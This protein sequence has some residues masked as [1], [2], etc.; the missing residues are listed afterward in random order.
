MTWGA[1]GATLL[2]FATSACTPLV[3]GAVLLGLVGVGALTSKCY[4]YLD[5]TVLDAD[6]RKTCAATVTASRRGKDG[7]DG[8]PL[9]L[10]SCYYTP[11]SDGRWT[12]RASLPGFNDAVSTV[13]V[14]HSHDCARHVQTVELTLSRPGAAPAPVLVRPPPSAPALPAQAPVSPPPAPPPSGV[15]PSAP[16]SSAPSSPPANSANPPVGTFPGSAEP[17]H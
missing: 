3:G 4:D 8:S 10:T 14:D 13:V 5:V 1:L 6:G 2:V 7:K 11:L 9:E 17:S 15:A 12:L 16:S